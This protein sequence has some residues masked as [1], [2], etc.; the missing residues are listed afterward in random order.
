[1]IKK[2]LVPLALVLVVAAC[3]QPNT[4]ELQVT[5]LSPAP[6]AINVPLDAVVSATFNT[7][8]VRSSVTGNFALTTG[9]GAPVEGEIDYDSASRTATFTPDEP[10]EYG[11]VYTASAEGVFTSGGSTLGGAA[12]WSF[13]TVEDPDQGGEVTS[14]SIDQD[15]PELVVGGGITFTAT[16]VADEGVSQAVTWSSSDEEV[17][18]VNSATGVVLALALGETTVTATSVADSTVADSVIVTVVPGTPVPAVLSLTIDPSEDADL[19]LGESLDIDYE[20]VVVGG[21]SSSITWTIT[22]DTAAISLS[23]TSTTDLVGTVTVTAEQEGEATLTA[24]SVENDSFQVEITITVAEP[25]VISVT[26][27]SEDFTIAIGDDPV[28]LLAIVDTVGGA[29]EDVTWLSSAPAFATIDAT[30][31]VVEAVAEGET[32]I[33][34]TS[35]VGGV[36]SEPIT[37]TVVPAAEVLSVTIEYDAEEVL[38]VE[39]Q[40]HAAILV[41]GQE[42]ELSADVEV[43]GGASQDVTWLSSDD[44]IATVDSDGVVTAAADGVGQVTITA[45]SA[46]DTSQTDTV[47]FY[48]VDEFMALIDEEEDSIVIEGLASIGYLFDDPFPAGLFIEGGV[49]DFTYEL[50]EGFEL[51]EPFTTLG[52]DGD[53]YELEFG[54]DGTFTGSTGYP[55]EYSGTVRITD[56]V[57][58]F[59]DVDYT[60]EL[61]VSLFYAGGEGDPPNVYTHV[62]GLPPGGA[63]TIVAGELVQLSGVD[64]TLLLPEGFL[65]NFE[66]DLEYVTSDG[67]EVV[68]MFLI[69]EADGTITRVTGSAGTSH[70]EYVVILTYDD[71]DYTEVIEYPIRFLR[72]GDPP[73]PDGDL[74]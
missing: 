74:G 55:G 35:V 22:G 72:E 47:T 12:S 7:Q 31:G 1:M 39:D 64:D 34:A 69:N 65:D 6:G 54:S 43:A 41:A 59:V 53:T 23:T 27:D 11:T 52:D 13:T 58:Q 2:L 60:L 62:S 38:V 25:A 48:V 17:A 46:A 29:S 49:G 24:T 10:L 73:F 45:T 20:I 16:V 32:Q 30:T 56:T 14:V 9:G 3:S 21:A 19:P 61:G 4:T 51:P 50:L 5:A 40:D 67:P 63:E 66:F 42:L 37:V 44:D 26:I 33:T 8:V 15:A 70:H 36:V 28:T 68:G 71:G 57:G 18:T